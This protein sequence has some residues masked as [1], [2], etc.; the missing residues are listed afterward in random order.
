M[1]DYID[2]FWTDADLISSYTRAQAIE[3]GALI[4]VTDTAKQLFKIPVA[5]TSAV[6]NDINAIPPRLQGIQDPIGRLWDILWMGQFAAKGAPTQ[7]TITYRLIMHISRTTYYTVKMVIGGGD[8]GEPVIT[9]MRPD[10]D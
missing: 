9:L 4:D 8:A 5:V 2:T 6:W 7:D 3:D 10:E 1:N